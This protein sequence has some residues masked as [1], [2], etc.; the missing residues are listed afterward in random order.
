MSLLPFDRAAVHPHVFIVSMLY[1][2]FGGLLLINAVLGEE[3]QVTT[4]LRE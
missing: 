2:D 4:L 1:V 3:T